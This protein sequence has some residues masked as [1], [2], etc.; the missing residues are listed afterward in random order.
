MAS[1]LTNQ[2]AVGSGGTPPAETLY[3]LNFGPSVSTN[4]D[5]FVGGSVNYSAATGY[6]WV[7]S[8]VE[9]PQCF[10]RINALG[11]KS[12]EYT[13]C[14]VDFYY[15]DITGN[16]VDTGFN[17]IRYRADV[18]NDDYVVDVRAGDPAYYDD[19]HE[20]W[21]SVSGDGGNTWVICH[22][23]T[24][25]TFSTLNRVILSVTAGHILFKFGQESGE[26]DRARTSL[27]SIKI[28]KL[29]SPGDPDP[30]VNTAP[31]VTAG[32]SR[33]VSV[34]STVNLNGTVTDD[35]LPIGSVAHTWTQVSGPTAP[36][37]NPT[38]LNTTVL[39]PTAGTYVYRLTADDSA[40]SSNSTV[41][42]TAVA[43]D[44]GGGGGSGG[45]GTDRHLYI[46][47]PAWSDGL[48]EWKQALIGMGKQDAANAIGY[49]GFAFQGN[50]ADRWVPQGEGKWGPGNMY[51]SLRSYNPQG[52]ISI[53]WGSDWDIEI[54]RPSHPNNA[55]WVSHV[56]RWGRELRDAQRAGLVA[57]DIIVAT[58]WE[59]TGKYED[60][61]PGGFTNYQI[62][63][64]H[65][66][67]D[68]AYWFTKSRELVL[69]EGAKVKFCLAPNGVGNK[70]IE[71]I[72]REV[73]T[74]IGTANYDAI[75][76][77]GYPLAQFYLDDNK[78]TGTGSWEANNKYRRMLDILLD[79][80]GGKELVINEVGFMRPNWHVDVNGKKVITNA[81]DR[82]TQISDFWQIMGEY[83]VK[84]V[85]YFSHAKIP[86]EEFRLHNSDNHVPI[87]PKN[88]VAKT[89][90]STYGA[91]YA[92]ERSYTIAER[93]EFLRG[94]A[95]WQAG[96]TPVGDGT[97][98]GSTDGG[99]TDG[100]GS[101]GGSGGDGTAAQF[102]FIQDDD[103]IH[104]AGGGPAQWIVPQVN[105]PTGGL[106]AYADGGT[107]Y[108]RFEVVS[109]PSNL[110]VSGQLCIW[111]RE[112]AQWTSFEESCS[113]WKFFQF[114][115]PGVYYVRYP[116]PIKWHVAVSD[117]SNGTFTWARP[118][119]KANDVCRLF[120]RAVDDNNNLMSYD[121]AGKYAY[122]RPDLANHI[123]ITVKQE[124]WAVK[125][126]ATFVPPA[127]WTGHPW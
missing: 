82:I 13:I 72:T 56:K 52:W 98:D 10:R 110:L 81:V 26:P 123:P 62:R 44:G 23:Y 78:V 92:G 14:R 12:E 107:F 85:K 67:A 18:P 116:N 79:I 71:D 60:M 94:Y 54:A 50:G 102:K 118:S 51:V 46:F 111:Q 40:L 28:A 96:G 1:I 75:G 7:D 24:A 15:N 45:G 122:T 99:E 119:W 125:P 61:Y 65:S 37:A 109:K 41:T 33:Q 105:W 124:W 32:N 47:G 53:Q 80:S 126:G 83:D 117:R 9:I 11:D 97:G 16:W 86:K 115:Q 66:A 63:M 87:L 35:G 25:Q 74:A 95:V 20:A 127:S 100:G 55:A 112:N 4:P 101:G 43:D 69:A 93:N 31:V 48:L 103:I 57:E 34:G 19:S 21:V 88:A 49:F 17:N 121:G 6:G 106:L 120:M 22:D 39:L 76:M 113:P 30:P 64:G 36:P 90:Y 114:T 77:S 5:G 8:S 104:Q 68:F 108:A 27:S 91:Q 70:I 29:G 3:A 73:S 2:T 58:G 84:H 59:F 42:Y 89:D 38:L